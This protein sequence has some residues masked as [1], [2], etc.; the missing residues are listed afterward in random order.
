MKAH[1]IGNKAIRE[2]LVALPEIELEALSGRLSP[3]PISRAQRGTSVQIGHPE[4][5]VALPGIEPG[6]ED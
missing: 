6:F 1:A 4:G 5:L 2:G 3:L